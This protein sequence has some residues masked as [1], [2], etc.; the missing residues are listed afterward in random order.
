MHLMRFA[1]QI[2]VLVILAHL[3][4]SIG[5]AIRVVMLRRPVGVSLAWL[6]LIF[7]WPFAGA[8]VYLIVGEKHLGKQHAARTATIQARYQEWMAKLPPDAVV[9]YTSL[10]R[11]CVPISRLAAATLGIPAMAGNRLELIDQAETNLRSI[12]ADIDRAERTCHLEFYIWNEGGT[13]DEVGDALIRA[14]R[15]GVACRVLVDAIGSAGFMEGHLARRLRQ[16]GVEV[17]AALPTGPLRMF[18]VRVDLRLHRKI[19]VIDG[20]VAY[21]GSMNL[22]DPRFFKRNAGVGQW[23]DAMVRIE[24]PAVRALGALFLWDWQVE[25]GQD[26]S[27]S[28]EAGVEAAAASP[29]CGTVNVQVVPSGPGHEMNPIYQVLLTSIYTVRSELIITTPY[30]VPDESLLT[31]LLSAAQRGV[32][33]TVI[34]PEK[35]DSLLVRYACRSY[36]DDLLTAGVRILRFQGGLLHTKSIV[37]DGKISLFG[38]VNV[39]PRSF[40]LD[41]EVTL[42]VYDADFGGRLRALQHIYAARS[43]PVDLPTWRQRPWRKRFVEN[44]AHL[45]APLL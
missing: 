42:C 22:V 34:L 5:L 21:T 17:V 2:I 39:D 41:F 32:K 23:V 6:F 26:I 44:L 14:V 1:D 31:A 9:D 30:F 43:E 3:V 10:D 18:F 13:A 29:R 7:A 33:V 35:I 25:T 28:A 16:G 20:R 24:G 15:R 45:F 8:V 4:I 37:I 11:E 40:W 36:F 38:T 27:A 12:I 19:V